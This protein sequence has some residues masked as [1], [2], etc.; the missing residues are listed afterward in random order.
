MARSKPRVGRPPRAGKAASLRF[1]L[2]LTPAEVKRWQTL[3]D[4]QGI[5]LSEAVREAMDAAVARGSTR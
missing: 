1:E 4:R 2:R 3:A 5:S